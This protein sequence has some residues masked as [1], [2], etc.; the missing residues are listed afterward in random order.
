MTEAADVPDLHPVELGYLNGGAELAA[1]VG[2]V[3]LHERAMLVRATAAPGGLEMVLTEDRGRHPV[4]HAVAAAV[5]A[6]VAGR[7]LVPAVREASAMVVVRDRLVGRALLAQRLGRD[8]PTRRG[9]SVL[10]ATRAPF[11]ETCTGTAE[12]DQVPA[13]AGEP[14]VTAGAPAAALQVAAVGSDELPTVALGLA[15][16]LGILP[17][18]KH[19]RWDAGAVVSRTIRLRATNNSRMATGGDN[20]HFDGGNWGARYGGTHG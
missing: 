14:A 8:R 9:R 18:P 5:A 16:A 6:G 1:I 13:G 2:C 12:P 11:D 10:V 20:Q 4:E 7:A 19:V 17:R 15:R 3:G